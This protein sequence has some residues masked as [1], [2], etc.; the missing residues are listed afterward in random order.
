VLTDDSAAEQLAVKGA[1]RGVNEFGGEKLPDHFLC[2]VH[3]DRTLRRNIADAK[4]L[5]H[6]RA[7]V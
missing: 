4:I 1:F 5:K 2:T 6:I 7:A 3:S